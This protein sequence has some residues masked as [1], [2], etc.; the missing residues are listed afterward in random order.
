MAFTNGQRPKVVG[1]TGAR[2]RVETRYA[3]DTANVGVGD[4]VYFDAS[5]STWKIWADSG[6]PGGLYLGTDSGIVNNILPTPGIN[7]TGAGVFGGNGSTGSATPSAT[8]G[9][10][11][12]FN[13]GTIIEIDVLQNNDTFLAGLACGISGSKY[14]SATSGGFYANLN[15]TTSVDSIMKVYESVPTSGSATLYSRGLFIFHDA[16]KLA[17]GV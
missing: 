12:V 16:T 8:T 15:A 7:V 14:A 4:I 2:P 9:A 10:V 3:V 6:V 17:P 11:L 13:V 5:D 1:Y